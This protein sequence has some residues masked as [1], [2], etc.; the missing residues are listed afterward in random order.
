MSATECSSPA[1]IAMTFPRSLGTSH[2]PSS[3]IPLPRLSPQQITLPA[4]VSAIEWRTP[5]QIAV[6]G[7]R[8]PGTTEWLHQGLPP[9]DAT[10]P[11]ALSAYVCSLPAKIAVT[12]PRPLGTSHWPESAN[13]WTSAHALGFGFAGRSPSSLLAVSRGR[14]LSA[15]TPPR[16][17]FPQ[18][19]ICVN[20]SALRRIAMVWP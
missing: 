20:P 14:S 1:L 12:I 2:R 19:T 5:A 10:L 9:Q 8:P 6:I 4:A 7:S 3:P 15:A 18:L 11:S 13:P 17:Q 16:L